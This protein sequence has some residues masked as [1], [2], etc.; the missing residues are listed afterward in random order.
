MIINKWLGK[1]IVVNQAIRICS[2]D[3]HPHKAAYVDAYPFVGNLGE[4]IRICIF[5]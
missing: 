1:F 4:K 5:F 3:M 2:E